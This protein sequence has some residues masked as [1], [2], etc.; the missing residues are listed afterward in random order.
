MNEL[1]SQEPVDLGRVSAYFTKIVKAHQVYRKM[2]TQFDSAEYLHTAIR[3]NNEH[4]QALIAVMDQLITAK[5]A[6]QQA[7]PATQHAAPTAD[8]KTYEKQ[9]GA[10]YDFPAMTVPKRGE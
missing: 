2:S 8:N 6:T 7:A 5:A 3:S 10:A 4:N 1:T 9:Y